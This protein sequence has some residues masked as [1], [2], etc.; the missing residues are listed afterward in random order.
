LCMEKGKLKLKNNHN[1]YY[2]CQ[3]LSNICKLPWVDFVIRT[4]NP[5][6]LHVEKIYR[7]EQLWNC[8][9]PKLNAF[10]IKALLPEISCPRY[11][12]NPGI[13]ESGKW[14]GIIIQ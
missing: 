8:W 14:V 6:Q 5:Y 13:R 12:K 3:A 2:Q 10:Y 1:Y 4:V 11:G 9:L 7:N